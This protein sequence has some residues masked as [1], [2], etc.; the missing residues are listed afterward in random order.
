MK[1][2]NLPIFLVVLVTVCLIAG[3]AL[4]NET[5]LFESL[6]DNRTLAAPTLTVTTCGTTVSFSWTSVDGGT[7]YTLYYAPSPY[8]G[9]DSIGSIPLGIQTSMSAS[10]VY[11]LKFRI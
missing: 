9:P 1:T 6:S 2:R 10:T 4:A 11:I 5:A 8:T 3:T 7:G